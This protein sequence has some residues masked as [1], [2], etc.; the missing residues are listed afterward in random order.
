MYK[1]HYDVMVEKY[2]SKAKLLL[3]DTD[4]LC[5]HIRTDNLFHDMRDYLHLLDTS[6]YPK[7]H[8][9][10]SLKNDRKLGYF[11]DELGS[12][13]A[14][15]FAGLRAKMYSLRMPVPQTDKMTAKGIKRSYAKKHLKHEKFLECLQKH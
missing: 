13:Q 12:E 2:G 8:P 4:S 6:N 11:K 1:F 7:D 3:T 5:Y 15:E 14:V 10:F 9:C